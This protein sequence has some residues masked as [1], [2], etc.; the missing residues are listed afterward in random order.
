[1]A[2]PIKLSMMDLA[3][4]VGIVFVT[5]AVVHLGA[6][7]ANIVAPSWM[8]SGIAGAVG[9]AIWFLLLNRRKKS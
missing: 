7:A 9:V 3:I 1:M 6:G 5:M 4:G 2:E 8:L